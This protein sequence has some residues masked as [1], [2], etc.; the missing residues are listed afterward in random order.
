MAHFVSA[1]PGNAFLAPLTQ[2]RSGN[3]GKCAQTCRMKYTLEDEDGNSIN[4][5]GDF[6]LSP[7][8]LALFEDIKKLI[9]ANIL[10][11]KI[12]GRMKS[13][14]YVGHV[15]K[16]YSNLINNYKNS[17]PMHVIDNDIN[18]LKKAI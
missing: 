17:A 18:D 7:K 6:L 4:S 16:I 15:T 12:E 13:P 14:Q 8:D 5:N 3:R 1:I 11:Y 2:N 9:D 10:S